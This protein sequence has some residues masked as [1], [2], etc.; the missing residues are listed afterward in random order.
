[1]LK[2]ELIHP[3]ISEVLA[4]AGHSSKIL[5]ADGNYPASSAMGP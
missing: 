3:K 5:I 1:M 2:S 4:K